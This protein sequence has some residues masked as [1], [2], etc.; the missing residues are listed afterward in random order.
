VL[1]A[2]VADREALDDDEA[3]AIAAP[4]EAKLIL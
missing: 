1:A 3:A 2:L 4:S